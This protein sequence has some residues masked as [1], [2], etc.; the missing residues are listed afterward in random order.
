MLTHRFTKPSP[1]RKTAVVLLDEVDQLYTKKQDVLYNMFDWPTHDHSHL[2]LVAVANTMDLPERVFHQRVASRLG[3]TRLT[4]MPYTHQQ[5]VSILQHRLTQFDCFTHD[6]IELCSRKV[7]AVS[8]DARRALTICQRAAEIARAKA[9]EADADQTP[10]VSCSLC[11]CA[12]V[13]VYVCVCVCLCVC[14]CA[15]VICLER[16]LHSFLPL[17]IWLCVH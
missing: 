6:A 11:V 16:L 13:C 12:C 8:G 17:P 1:R 7:S 15:C 14:L 2:I 4:F 10:K 5:L 3:L 9:G